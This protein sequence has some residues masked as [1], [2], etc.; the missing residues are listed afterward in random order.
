[1][2]SGK[3]IPPEV[4]SLLTIV[5]AILAFFVIPDEIAICHFIVIR[6]RS[7][8]R[9]FTEIFAKVSVSYCKVSI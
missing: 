2:K 7:A 1:L 8:D 4:L 9:V 6:T 5:F 3:V